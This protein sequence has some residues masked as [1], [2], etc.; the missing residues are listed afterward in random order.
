MKLGIFA[1]YGFNEQTR[2]ACALADTA[3]AWG[4]TTQYLCD[5]PK[6]DGVHSYWDGH[7]RSR[8]RITFEAW[9]EN[10]DMLVWFDIN[11]SLLARMKDVMCVNIIVPRWHCLT[12]D[13]IY[14]LK[15][16]EIV[17]AVNYAM[18]EA[19]TL[20]NLTN[21]VHTDWYAGPRP[22]PRQ[23]CVVEEGK[24]KLLV[25]LP[26]HVANAHGLPLLA[27]L[28][29]LLARRPR[30]HITLNLEH[31]WQKYVD[32]WLGKLIETGR[33]TV[34][35]KQSRAARVAAY[36]EH[37]WVLCPDTHTASGHDAVEALV[38]G[39]PVA[40]FDVAPFNEILNPACNGALLTCHTEPSV[41]NFPKFEPDANQL[42]NLFEGVASSP[43]LAETLKRRDWR[44]LEA[45]AQRF[46][47]AWREIWDC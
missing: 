24:L 15:N 47:Q 46:H 26:R 22:Y 25:P 7:V 33:V 17:A 35:R 30:L 34:R 13:D 4:I 19:L 12:L 14:E 29:V 41:A 38:Y 31:R 42:F 8:Q 11:K 3:R 44:L 39:C 1:P 20:H 43:G 40:A 36:G 21:V 9:A 28:H 10:L 16:Y 18:Y 2:M 37:D 5:G 45:R 23:P 6:A 32:A 27:A